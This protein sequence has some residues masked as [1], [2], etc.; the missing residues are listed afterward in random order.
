MTYV[1]W[2]YAEMKKE[3]ASSINVC[4]GYRIMGESGLAGKS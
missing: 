1:T 2:T 4:Q 3:K